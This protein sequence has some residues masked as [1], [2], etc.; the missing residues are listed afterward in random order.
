MRLV[1]TRDNNQEEAQKIFEGN[2]LLFDAWSS[3]SKDEEGHILL[4]VLQRKDKTTT[5][6]VC[7]DIY[8]THEEM[9][10]FLKNVASCVKDATSEPEMQNKKG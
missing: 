8:G 10:T 1:I 7:I 9:Q 5:D 2:V 4:N 3:D 6:E